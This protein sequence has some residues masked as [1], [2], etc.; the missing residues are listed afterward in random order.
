MRQAKYRAT[1]RRDTATL[2]AS[3]VP[4]LRPGDVVLLIGTLGSGKTSFVQDVAAALG[5][6][7]SPTSP[8]FTLA[9]F[10]EGTKLTLLHVDTYRLQDLREFRDLGLEDFMDD[11]V[12]FV[13]WG[14]LVA[15]EFPEH[16]RV[17]IDLLDDDD[18]R[19][20]TISSRSSR[21]DPVIEHLRRG[22]LRTVS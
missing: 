4:H 18:A 1:G 11:C 21:W 3:L 9:N 10:H 20:F 15:S 2:A 8:T 22:H 19:D 13:E 6:T 16:L 5:A 17:Q 7:D 12:T 14:D